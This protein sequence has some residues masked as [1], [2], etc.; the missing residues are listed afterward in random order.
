MLKG[1]TPAM[2]E[3]YKQKRLT[4]QSGRSPKNLTKPATGNRELVCLKTI[5]NKAMKNGRAER[6]PTQG[7]KLLKENN[8]RDRVLTS[9]EYIRLLAA[10]P[11]HQKPIVK[12]AYHTGM[13]RG[14][15][16]SLT[17]GQVDLKEGFIRLNP[18]HTKTNESRIVPL[19]AELMEMFKVMP[20]GL[21]GARVFTFQGNPISY[22]KVGFVRACKRAEIEDFTFHDLRHTFNTN[23]FRAGVP[24]PTIMK[25]T[26]HKSLSMFRRY[27]TISLD[28][29][30]EAV[31]KI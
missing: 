8:E 25:I 9:A 13:R 3:A 2:V 23:A 15:I 21:S 14:E 7:V 30:K 4:E 11:L 29:L 17:W 27:T 6:N 26:G 19:N 5:F 28:D 22:I 20:R 18:E 24:I 16:L 10:S 1:I 31:G 12:I